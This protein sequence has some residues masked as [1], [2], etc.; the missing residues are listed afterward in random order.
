MLDEIIHLI[1]K[2]L[3]AVHAIRYIQRRAGTTCSRR[4]VADFLTIAVCTIATSHW[5]TAAAAATVTLIIF[6]AVLT[7]GTRDTGVDRRHG[8]EPC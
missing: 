6:R 8:A 7:I 4:S 1:T 3:G 2:I 5:L